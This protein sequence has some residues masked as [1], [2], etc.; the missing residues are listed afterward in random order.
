MISSMGI[1][2]AAL[3][4]L[5]TQIFTNVIMGFVLKQIRENN[6]IMYRSLNPK[7]MISTIKA[8]C[9]RSVKKVGNG[10]PAPGL[11]SMG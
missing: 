3:A 5:I 9:E 4:S 11:Y 8:F 1:A 10:R 6:R 7:L 2:G